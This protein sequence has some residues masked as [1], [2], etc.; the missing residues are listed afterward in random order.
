M[1]DFVLLEVPR[2]ERRRRRLTLLATLAGEA[3]V[4]AVLVAV[5]LVYLDAIPGVSMHAQAAVLPVSFSPPPHAQ[6]ETTQRAS[7][8]N[9]RSVALLRST[10]EAVVRRTVDNP[11]LTYDRWRPESD[12]VTLDPRLTRTG[13]CCDNP[14]TSLISSGPYVP[15]PPRQADRLRVSS[16]DPG[17]ILRRVEPVYPPLAKATRTQGDVILH[18]TIG[19]AGN[20]ERLQVVSGH[21]MLVEAARAAVQQWR[22]RPYRLNGSPIEVETRITVRFRLAGD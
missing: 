22:F 18:A 13:P 9:T 15:P 11:T 10:D 7:Q 19:T 21:P 3:L 4:V 12:E 17:M 6:P 14:A 20:I 2:G 5:P 16:M 8:S 1:F